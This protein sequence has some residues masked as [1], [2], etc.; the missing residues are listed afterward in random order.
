M[1]IRDS[2]AG[3]SEVLRANL[4]EV[5]DTARA[6]VGAA[7]AAERRSRIWIGAG[8]G[9]LALLGVAGATSYVSRVNAEQ[10][11]ADDALLETNRQKDAAVESGTL[12]KRREQEANS[13][14]EEAQVAR[15]S[16]ETASK[17]AEAL[18]VTFERD[19]KTLEERIKK[20]KGKEL[21]DLQKELAQRNAPPPPPKVAPV[22]PGV[23][24]TVSTDP[25]F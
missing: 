16:A 14:K 22:A 1:C 7:R 13:A 18:K 23:G 12:A 11:R 4:V 8:L 3:A 25:V 10:K 17:E 20:A 19:L 9:A 24:S 6:F 5:S 15:K 21:E 2:L